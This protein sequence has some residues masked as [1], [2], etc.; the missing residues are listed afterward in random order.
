MRKHLHALCVI[1]IAIMFS[2]PLCAQTEKKVNHSV[3]IRILSADYKVLNPSLDAVRSLFVP[4]GVEFAYTNTI[5]DRFAFSL[6][7]KYH[8]ANISETQG[9]NSVYSADVLAKYFFYKPSNKITPYLMLGGGL[10]YEENENTHVQLP[11]GLGFNYMIGTHSMISF[12]SQY[13][14]SMVELRNNLQM[15]LGI[16]FTVGKVV[17]EGLVEDPLQ[18]TAEDVAADEEMPKPTFVDQKSIIQSELEETPSD[19][20]E[21]NISV[22][23]M[24]LPAETNVADRDNDGLIDSEDDCPD[25]FGK[26]N[27]NG[28]PDSDGDGIADKDDACPEEAGSS[29]KSG[30]PIQDADKDGIEDFEDACPDMPGLS[31]HNGCPD[32][33][34]DGIVDSEDNCPDIAGPIDGCPDADDDND[35][36]PNSKDRCPSMAGDAAHMGC[37]EMEKEEKSMLK[38]AADNIQFEFGKAH[39]K[40]VSY[41]TLDQI[42]DLLK[43]YPE[44]ELEIVGHTDDVGRK[45]SNL[46]LSLDRATSCRDYLISRKIDEARIKVLAEGEL[47]PL[48]NNDTEDGRE[49]NRRVEF[50]II[51]Q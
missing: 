51:G 18:M 5:N 2:T 3:Q 34:G 13:R 30:C 45:Q 48:G 15:A 49:K 17:E 31:K 41:K 22:Q 40:S 23:D 14:Y 36:I 16:S 39:L 27:L 7:F 21:K 37:P 50:N 33:D 46:E 1:A 42:A 47:K 10:V 38:L 26:A 12:E 6:P 29:S 9:S 20:S 43:K 19:Y 28:C 44:F 35:G 32:S 11:A 25:L 4:N 24:E 8:R